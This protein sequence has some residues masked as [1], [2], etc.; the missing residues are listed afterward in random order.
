MNDEVRIMNNEKNNFKNH[1]RLFIILYSLFTIHTF[2]S[3]ATT[4]RE[5]HL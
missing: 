4:A 1:S 3:T 2:S 5:T